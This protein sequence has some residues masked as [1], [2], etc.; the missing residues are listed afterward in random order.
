MGCCY[1]SL[2]QT[3]RTRTHTHTHTRTHTHTSISI[4]APRPVRDGTQQPPFTVDACTLAA[5][6]RTRFPCVC[7]PRCIM[8]Q[9]ETPN[10]AGRTPHSGGVFFK[11][12]RTSRGT[13]ED[14]MR[15]WSEGC[16]Q[17]NR[18][19]ETRRLDYTA[20][21]WG[22]LGEKTA[23]KRVMLRPKSAQRT[24]CLLLPL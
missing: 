23:Q 6:D 14:M 10:R 8:H 9:N 7:C 3:T 18:A 17:Q 11:T 2:T 19:A 21:V 24:A 16:A 22:L 1:V 4:P 20:L 13:R 12:E 15:Q 5:S